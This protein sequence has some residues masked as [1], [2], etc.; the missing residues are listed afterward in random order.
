MII[1]IDA[2]FT[3]FEEKHIPKNIRNELIHRHAEKWYRVM[4]EIEEEID[5]LLLLRGLTVEEIEKEKKRDGE[6]EKYN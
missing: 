5:C 4:A 6:K 2:K 3:G 1:S